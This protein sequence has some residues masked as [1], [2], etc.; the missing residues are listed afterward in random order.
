MDMSSIVIFLEVAK[1][2]HL[3]KANHF[4]GLLFTS[5]GKILMQSYRNENK[6]RTIDKIIKASILSA[7][8]HDIRFI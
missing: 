3:V 8:M 6:I 5:Y 1:N 7:S 4:F 2:C